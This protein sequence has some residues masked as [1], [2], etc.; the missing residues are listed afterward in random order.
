MDCPIALVPTELSQRGRHIRTDVTTGPF[1]NTCC[2][3]IHSI[4]CQYTHTHTHQPLGT[5][6]NLNSMIT[7]AATLLLVSCTQGEQRYW[8][9]VHK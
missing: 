3:S 1:C 8:S 2:L 9:A 4:I 6:N 5:H 7:D